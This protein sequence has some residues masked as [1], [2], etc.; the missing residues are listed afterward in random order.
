M[1]M[2]RPADI[3]QSNP[4]RLPDPTFLTSDLLMLREQVTRFVERAG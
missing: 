1:N 4:F 2:T 3:D